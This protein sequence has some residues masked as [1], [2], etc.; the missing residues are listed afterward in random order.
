LQNTAVLK[1]ALDVASM[2]L[3]LLVVTFTQPF[4]I[5]PRF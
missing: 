3:L 5:I 1:K 4:F 2:H